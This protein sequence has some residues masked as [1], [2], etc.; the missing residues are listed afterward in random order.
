M[1][2]LAPPMIEQLDKALIDHCDAPWILPEG[3]N[4]QIQIKS[5]SLVCAVM[6]GDDCINRR[7]FGQLRMTASIEVFGLPWKLLTCLGRI[8]TED[9]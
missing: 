2:M 7:M 8:Y 5:G 6:E 1:D 3:A 4:T 9:R